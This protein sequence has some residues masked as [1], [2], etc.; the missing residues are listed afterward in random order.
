MKVII[1]E[2]ET[3]YKDPNL[4]I[5]KLGIGETKVEV[6]IE[7]L[8]DK[9]SN[10]IKKVEEQNIKP[11]IN[12]DTQDITLHISSIV[13]AKSY[14]LTDNKFALIAKEHQ[15]NS[16]YLE[17]ATILKRTEEEGKL[18]VYEQYARKVAVTLKGNTLPQ[19]LNTVF[20][21]IKTV[22]SHFES[23][24]CNTVVDDLA[25]TRFAVG[26]VIS[27]DGYRGLNDY[28]M[29]ESG[30]TLYITSSIQAMTKGFQ[31]LVHSVEEDIKQNNLM[32]IKLNY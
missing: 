24:F 13:N 9:V 5:L 15:P 8:E 28:C 18:V 1:E 21:V 12:K 14:F 4:L 6:T 25:W 17:W 26:L 10:N 11:V 27:D 32:Q 19:N 30:V 16:F 22:M 23:S 29:I 7:N 3:S 31:D 20:P 2:V